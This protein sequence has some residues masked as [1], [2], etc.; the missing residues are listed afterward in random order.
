MRRNTRLALSLPT[1]V[2]LSLWLYYDKTGSAACSICAAVLHECGHFAVLRLLRDPPRR[3]H[4]GLF[5]ADMERE[6]TV[7]L[8]YRQEILASAAGP[9]VNILLAGLLACLL[10][11]APYLLEAVRVNLSLALF[12]LLPLRTLDGGQIV[13]AALCRRYLPETARRIQKIIAAGVSVPLAAIGIWLWKRGF[14]SYSL[15]L[16]SL[17]VVVSVVLP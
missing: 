4:V 17:F 2:W 6:S 9:A 3:L 10:P 13:Y 12:N 15:L 11:V 14:G 7:H 16:S 5:G 8:N 1:A